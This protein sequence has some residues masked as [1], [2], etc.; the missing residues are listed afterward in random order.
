MAFTLPD[1]PGDAEPTGDDSPAKT[2]EENH[3][4]CFLA[5]EIYPFGNIRY[6]GG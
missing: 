5:K 6:N 1:T 2:T 4:E 3:L